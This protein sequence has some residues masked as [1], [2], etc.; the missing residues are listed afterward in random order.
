MNNQDIINKSIAI[1][2]CW[3]G[4]YPWYFS[5]FLH[6]CSHN[7]NIDF[8]I[9]TDNRES[10]PIKANNVKI[11]Y[12]TLNEINVT[13]SQKLGLTVN[14]DY[15]YKLCDFKPAYGF[16]F[17]EL[18]QDYDFWGQSDI[19]I[20]Y[21]N[22]RGFITDEMLDTYDFISLRHDY[23][24]GCFAL[25]RNNEKMNRFFMRSKDYRLVFSSPE[26]Y[27]FTE[28]NFAW[29]ELAAGKS[30]FELETKIDSFTYLIKSAELKKEINA[31]FDFI[32]MEGKTGRVVF[33]NGKIIYKKQ[34]EAVLYHLFWLKSVTPEKVPQRIPNKYYISPTRIYHSRKSKLK[35]IEG[36]K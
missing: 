11:I 30:I 23:T 3:Y 20:I 18:I 34:F 15:P 25:Y 27:S 8:F 26:F 35:S 29:D 16:L 6:S 10:L 17:P 31:H 19:D 21:G 2:T 28:C 5:Y 36:E 12:K 22:I 9:I 7:P 33:D 14:I 24:T 13:A 4:P 32:L 1:I